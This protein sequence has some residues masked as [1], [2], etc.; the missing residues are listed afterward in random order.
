MQQLH[1]LNIKSGLYVECELNSC[2]YDGDADRVGVATLGMIPRPQP[3][4]LNAGFRVVNRAGRDFT[5]SRYRF[6]PIILKNVDASV[7][8]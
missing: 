2:D 8:L 5:L 7:G 4:N 1:V 3:C 6:W